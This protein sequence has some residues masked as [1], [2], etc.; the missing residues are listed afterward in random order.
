MIEVRDLDRRFQS[1]RCI[2]SIAILPHFPF[3]DHF[4]LSS[5]FVCAHKCARAVC[6]PFTLSRLHVHSCLL[7]FTNF[8]LFSCTHTYIVSP[9][10]D[11]LLFC[12]FFLFVFCCS[13]CCLVFCFFVNFFFVFVKVKAHSSHLIWFVVLLHV[14]FS[15]FLFSLVILVVSSKIYRRLFRFWFDI[16]ETMVKQYIRSNSS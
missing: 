5:F 4:F 15:P 14:S 7:V 2:C 1:M 10:T 13:C 9:H 3:T 12:C 8:L 16:S 6:V 11:Y